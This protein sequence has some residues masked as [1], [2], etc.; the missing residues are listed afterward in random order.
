MVSVY[1]LEWRLSRSF[2]FSLSFFLNF[3]FLFGSN[4]F[5]QEELKALKAQFDRGNKRKRE[6]RHRAE[7]EKRKKKKKKKNQPCWTGLVSQADYDARRKEIIKN[8]TGTDV[9]SAPVSSS[10]SSSSSS[11]ASAPV[12]KARRCAV[13]CACLT[14][15]L[16]F[17]CVARWARTPRWRRPRARPTIPSL[18]WRPRT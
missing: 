13:V 9:K 18:A 15:G 16:I 11:G 10:S 5:V 8:L 4:D 7:T 3:F 14:C 17:V 1:F 2:R 6:A 12:T